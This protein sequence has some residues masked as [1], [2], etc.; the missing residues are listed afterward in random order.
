MDSPLTNIPM[1]ATE[2]ARS[3]SSSGR[4]EE[5]RPVST[6]LAGSI[7]ASTPAAAKTTPRIFSTV[8]L[9]RLATGDLT[10]FF[11]A[12]LARFSRFSARYSRR[13]ARYSRR[14]ARLSV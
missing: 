8:A 13:S 10:T 3:C 4:Y 2:M 5:V 7:A 1:P 6:E 11:A 12:F 14:S 9:D